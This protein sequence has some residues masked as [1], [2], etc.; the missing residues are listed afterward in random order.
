MALNARNANPCP[1]RSEMTVIRREV[2]PT[3]NL[4]R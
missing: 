3:T 1:E 2:C 4:S